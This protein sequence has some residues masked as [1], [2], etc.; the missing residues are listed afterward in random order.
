MHKIRLRLKHGGNYMWL[1]GIIFMFF[2]FLYA[3]DYLSKVREEK[4][5]QMLFLVAQNFINNNELD[6]LKDVRNILSNNGFISGCKIEK[7]TAKCIYCKKDT[8]YVLSGRKYIC[9]NPACKKYN[10]ERISNQF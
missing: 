5:K 10:E 6:D 1:I 8:L 7:H 9:I 4:R 3:H 2:F